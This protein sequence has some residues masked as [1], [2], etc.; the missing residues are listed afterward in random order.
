MEDSAFLFGITLPGRSMTASGLT[1]KKIRT[2]NN[3]PLRNP[4]YIATTIGLAA[5]LL[6]VTLYRWNSDQFVA[7]A[8]LTAVPNNPQAPWSDGIAL[9]QKIARTLP[10]QQV[11][12]D[13]QREGIPGTNNL[14]L[15]SLRDRVVFQIQPDSTPLFINFSLSFT[16]E[17]PDTSIAFVNHLGNLLTR[18]HSAA[19]NPLGDPADRGTVWHM[20]PASSSRR[21][22]FPTSLSTIL[23][24]TLV[25]ILAAVSAALGC[26]RT[27][28]I[29]TLKMTKKLLAVP[30][31]GTL[32]ERNQ[33]GCRLQTP[34][35][36]L[37]RVLLSTSEWM[38]CG[39][40]LATFLAIA[41]DKNF[42]D[43]FS[44]EPLSALADGVR[45]IAEIPR[46]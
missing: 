5:F 13:L 9:Q 33:R 46:S 10:L 16:S 21:W 22:Y 7:V 24:A 3:R 37:L 45:Y 28:T 12:V 38:L 25:G 29:G 35:S 20:I 6:V 43:H 32:P 2:G 8:E 39:M 19:E 42:A 31:V 4:W 23:L 26:G 36:Q 40:L 17:N 44:A 27:A 11:V 18:P 41:L 34:S 30:I 14:D 1:T 15:A